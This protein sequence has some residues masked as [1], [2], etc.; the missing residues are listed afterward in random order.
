[1][2]N[3]II[4]LEID[5][6][7]YNIKTST[8]VIFRST[9]E[10]G[11]PLNPIGENVITYDG[12]SYTMEKG[13]FDNRYNKA[14]KNFLPNLFYAIIKS[15]NPTDE[16]FNLMLTYPLENEKVADEF[17]SILTDKEFKVEY[18]RGQKIVNRNIKIHDVKCIGESL[19]SYYTLNPSERGE[20]LFIVNI[21]GR[22]SD[23]SVFQNR[24]MVDKFTIPSGTLDLF[25]DILS[26][27]N[28]EHGD[29]KKVEDAERLIN[30]GYITD[31]EVEYK[32]F[33][34][35]L[36]NKIEKKLDRKT[37]IN[38]YTGGGSELLKDLI[39]GYLSPNGIVM[40]NPLFSDANGSREIA[41]VIR[42]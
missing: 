40:D 21:G 38:Y 17:K 5:L 20:D 26:R 3:N 35:D 37:Y 16:E 41:A 28:N 1:M 8:G 42:K 6:G 33:L 25:E 9:F 10:H 2:K 19:S 13:T 22:T 34:D 31:C 18:Q 24:R 15:S 7:N 11:K 14:K 29:N 39:E 4:N 32:Q 36:M 27:W 30:K 23:V 12:K